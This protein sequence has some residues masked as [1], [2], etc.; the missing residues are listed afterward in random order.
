MI[1][2]KTD[3]YNVLKF[4]LV[5]MFVDG[6]FQKTCRPGGWSFLQRVMWTRYKKSHGLGFLSVV[7]PNG[8]TIFFQGPSPGRHNVSEVKLFDFQWCC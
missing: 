4:G 6:T 1:Q 2:A 7:A 5:C 8:L 3:T